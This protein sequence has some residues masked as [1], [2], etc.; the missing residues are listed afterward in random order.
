MALHR[1]SLGQGKPKIIHPKITYWSTNGYI[2]KHWRGSIK[3]ELRWIFTKYHV[4]LPWYQSET[5]TGGC[6]RKW[7]SEGVKWKTSQCRQSKFQWGSFPLM[8]I[9]HWLFEIIGLSSSERHFLG[10][11]FYELQ[12]DSIFSFLEIWLQMKVN[13][14]VIQP[15]FTTWYSHV[16]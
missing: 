6:D 16:K 5:L 13:N 2:W 1:F 10:K 4:L 11:V 12:I 3:S 9:L 14:I 15:W 7:K 8:V